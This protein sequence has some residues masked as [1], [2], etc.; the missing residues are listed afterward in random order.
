MILS[1]SAYQVA[2]IIDLNHWHLA[3]YLES[4]FYEISDFFC[5]YY[6]GIELARQMLYLLSHDPSPAT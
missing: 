6:W 4:I 2:R 1:I 3:K 5:V